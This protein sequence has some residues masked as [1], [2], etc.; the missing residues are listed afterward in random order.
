MKSRTRNKIVA[1]TRGFIRA[2]APREYEQLK[3]ALK[4]QPVDDCLPRSFLTEQ[5]AEILEMARRGGNNFRNYTMIT[6]FV[7]SGVRVSELCPLKLKDI[8]FDN[9]TIK[10]HPKR[11]KNTL[12][13]RYVNTDAFAILRNYVTYTFGEPRFL[14]DDERYVFTGTGRTTPITTRTVELMVQDLMMQCKT[15]TEADRE[16]LSVHSFRHYYALTQLRN[17]V[18]IYTISV[19]LGHKSVKSTE[20]YLKL[21]KDDLRD[22]VNRL[23]LARVSDKHLVL[24]YERRELQR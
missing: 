13:T 7:G 5:V 9:E 10:V 1:F 24:I 22:A 14:S 20:V 11:A 16:V 21:F 23:N 19:L 2:M 17:G 4:L 6:V 3:H 18:D 15:I 8:D 12:A